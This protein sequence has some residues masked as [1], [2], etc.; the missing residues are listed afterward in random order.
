MN[1][2]YFNEE[3]LMLRNMVQEFAVNEIKPLAQT[4]DQEGIFPQDSIT[5]LECPWLEATSVWQ[6]LLP[7]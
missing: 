7:I 6:N 5:V 3:H 4:I 2:I 1:S